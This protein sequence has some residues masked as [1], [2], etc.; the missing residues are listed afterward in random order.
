M[1][2]PSSSPRAGGP[3][4]LEEEDSEGKKVM[5]KWTEEE[6][7]QAIQLL[8][9]HGKQWALISGEMGGTKKPEQIKNFFSV[10]PI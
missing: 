1:G 4:Q 10:S 9:V 5:T 6:K 2:V 7:Q 8:E 3:R